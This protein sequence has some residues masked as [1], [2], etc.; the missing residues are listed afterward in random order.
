MARKWAHGAGVNEKIYIA[1]GVFQ[2]SLLPESCQCE[3]YDETTNEWQFITSF[4]IGNTRI[5]TLLAV[6]GEL[7]GLSSI[8]SFNENVRIDYYNPKTN[9][10]THKTRLGILRKRVPATIMCSMKIFKG[11]FNIRPMFEAFPAGSFSRATTTQPSFHL[12]RAPER[13]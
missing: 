7:Y 11:L 3:V 12:P 4:V 9:K 5:E 2:G 13:K 6:D 1:G 8:D 10:W